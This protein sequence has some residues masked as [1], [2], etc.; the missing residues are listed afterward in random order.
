MND[1]PNLDAVLYLL[2]LISVSS[3][4]WIALALLVRALCT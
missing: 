2:G 1:H 4:L 3:A